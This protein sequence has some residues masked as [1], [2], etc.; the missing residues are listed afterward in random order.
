MPRTVTLDLD[1]AHRE[2]LRGSLGSTLEDIEADLASGFR[3]R[4]RARAKGEARLYRRLIAALDGHAMTADPAVAALVEKIGK[5]ADAATEY[6]Q[7][8]LEHDAHAALLEA[9]R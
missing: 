6:E 3:M 7:T 9:L 5:Q 1:P 2:L 8:V 4:D